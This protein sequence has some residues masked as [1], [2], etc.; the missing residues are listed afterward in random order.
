[1]MI[2]TK[3]NLLYCGRKEMGH[4]FIQNNGLNIFY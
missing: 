2:I 1:M 3:N 4:K